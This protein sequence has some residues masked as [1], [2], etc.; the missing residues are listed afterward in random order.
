MQFPAKLLCFTDLCKN[1]HED[2][3]IRKYFLFLKLSL[4]LPLILLQVIEFRQ[5]KKQKKIFYTISNAVY[6]F[7]F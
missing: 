2:K 5:N 3:V 4:M 7:A 1:L 6:F